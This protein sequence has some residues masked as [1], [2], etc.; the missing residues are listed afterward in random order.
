[1]YFSEAAL[2]ALFVAY[3]SAGMTDSADVTTLHRAKGIN[4]V[5]KL[6]DTKTVPVSRRTEELLIT[7]THQE[8]YQNGFRQWHIT[9]TPSTNTE[10]KTSFYE[11][12]SFS[13]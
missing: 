11:I 13:E 12:L 5:Q 9:S 7:G 8:S 1:M 10:Y 2:C 4:V 3:L 6:L